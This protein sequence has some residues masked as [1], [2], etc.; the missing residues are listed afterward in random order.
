MIYNFGFAKTKL[1]LDLD[2]TNVIAEL[3]PN[4]VEFSM[5]GIEEVKRSLEH[6]IGSKRLKDLV[7]S[8]EKV[9]II[10]SDITRPMPSKLVKPGKKPV[11]RLAKRP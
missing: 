10:T 5:I 3:L 6:P 1:A 9:V 7:R 2:E 4:K 11:E 8:G